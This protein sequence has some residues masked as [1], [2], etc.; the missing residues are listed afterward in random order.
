M[1]RYCHFSNP[2]GVK[3]TGSGTML[4]VAS[5][6][7]QRHSLD[8][9][10]SH[11]AMKSRLGWLQEH[12][13]GSDWTG[14]NIDAGLSLSL[15]FSLASTKRSTGENKLLKI[16]QSS[17][18]TAY[19]NLPAQSFKMCPMQTN[20]PMFKM[21]EV[22]IVPQLSAT[23]WEIHKGFCFSIS[24]LLLSVSRKKTISY[25]VRQTYFNYI[26]KFFR[27]LISIV[28]LNFLHLIYKWALY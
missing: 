12:C 23:W 3:D 14:F 8:M 4:W 27:W 10:P 9:P 26:F 2:E 20:K 13:Q 18:D 6:F 19:L 1:T 28:H 21:A 17:A 24:G 5:L 22:E 15:H 7:C 11:A 25:C 16:I